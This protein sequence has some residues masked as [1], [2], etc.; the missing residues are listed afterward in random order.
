MLWYDKYR[1]D[2]TRKVTER[3]F[4]TC[5]QVTA[6]LGISEENCNHLIRT[7]R[8]FLEGFCLL[9]GN[10]HSAIRCQ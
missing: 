7:F 3:L 9:A 6:S 10:L 2:E 4:S 8:A 1:D 5:F